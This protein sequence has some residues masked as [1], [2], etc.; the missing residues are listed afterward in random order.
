MGK[1]LRGR[2]PELHREFYR[3]NRIPILGTIQEP[4]RSKGAIASGWMRGPWPSVWG[5]A[6]MK[7]GWFNYKPFWRPW[8]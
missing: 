5:S 4:V 7:P 2:E 6:Q 8:A 1:T 3:S